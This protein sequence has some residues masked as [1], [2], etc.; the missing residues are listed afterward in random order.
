MNDIMHDILDSRSNSPKLTHCWS[1]TTAIVMVSWLHN[2]QVNSSSHTTREV[3]D[4]IRQF[5]LLF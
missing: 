2:L 5:T 3:Y 1:G 4:E